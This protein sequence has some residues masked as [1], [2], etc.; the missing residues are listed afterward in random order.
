MKRLTAVLAGILLP[1]ALCLAGC[2]GTGNAGNESGTSAAV[3]EQGSAAPEEEKPGVVTGQGLPADTQV[4]EK[5]IVCD[6]LEEPVRLA[7]VSDL[8]LIAREDVSEGD[9]SEGPFAIDPAS[10]ETIARRDQFFARGG[11]T[12]EEYWAQLAPQ[13]DTL[14]ADAVLLGADMLDFI[15]PAAAASLQEGLEKIRTPMLYV[16]ADHDTGLWYCGGAASEED[17]AA[18]QDTLADNRDIMVLELS[19]LKVIGINNSTSQIS[20]DALYWLGYELSV[21]RDE[22]TPAVILTHVPF[23][24]QKDTGLAKASEEAWDGRRLYWGQDAWHVPD[25]NTAEILELLYAED[26]PVIAVLSGHL[27]F[28]YEGELADN[29]VHTV[30]YVCE[31]AFEHRITVFTI[32]GKAD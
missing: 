21:C 15:T 1:A 14:D 11:M 17:A 27:H 20:A 26:S 16:R 4:I 30:Q 18:L 31:P 7:F 28:G 13:L 24:P 25:S 12:A 8:H 2:A 22:G 9:A 6:G 23:A 32:Q 5:T 3:Q 10:R 29:A 19:G